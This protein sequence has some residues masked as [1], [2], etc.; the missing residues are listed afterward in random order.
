MTSQK[1]PTL[2][3]RERTLGTR[4]A[5][6]AP[7]FAIA[8]SCSQETTDTPPLIPTA[9]WIKNVQE[10]GWSGPT[11]C[12]CCISIYKRFCQ[13][14]DTSPRGAGGW[15][16]PVT[17][18]LGTLRRKRKQ[19][20]RFETD[21]RFSQIIPTHLL[22]QMQTYPKKYLPIFPSQNHLHGKFQIHKKYLVIR[23]TQ[24]H[25]YGFRC[26]LR[27][28]HTRR[29]VAAT[30]HV[31]VTNRFVCT[32]EFL[33]FLQQNFVVATSCKKSNQTVFCVTCRGDK[34][35]LQRQRFSQ[36]FSSTLE[37]ICCCEV[38]PQHVAATCN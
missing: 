24:S 18:A 34:I 23:V 22:C 5:H 31:A 29:K 14:I 6:S 35:L 15:G 28:V 25:F 1:R 12:N 32:R 20:C 26:N 16:F 8:V 17:S 30:R 33:D 13:G 2:E 21:F 9:T 36:N 27:S 19:K 7:D 37:A 4:L 38:S 10:L 3:A 11:S